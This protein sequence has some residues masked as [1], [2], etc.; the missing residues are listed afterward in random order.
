MSRR[1]DFNLKTKNGYDFFEVSST[2]Q[3]AIRRGDAKVAGIAALELFPR[4]RNYTWKRLLTISV[5]DT[6]GIITN[7]IQALYNAFKFVNEGKNKAQGRIFIS[8]A[9][10]LLCEAKKSRDADH[11]QNL[12]YDDIGMEDEDVQRYI[13]ELENEPMEIPDYAYDVHTRKGKMMGKTKRDF[14][15]EEQK[16]LKPRQMSLFDDYVS[17]LE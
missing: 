14:F 11:L 12:V 8:K 15:I 2:L 9:V 13:E 4:Y 5:E 6:W 7:E 10:I 3:K 1:R 16:A 17:R